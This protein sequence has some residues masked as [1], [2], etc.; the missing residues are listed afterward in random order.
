MRQLEALV[1]EAEAA[2]GE[3]ERI[4]ALRRTCAD[5]HQEAWARPGDADVRRR[6]VL[7]SIDLI[8]QILAKMPR[9]G[10]LMAKVPNVLHWK[11][12]RG[13]TYIRGECSRG[14]YGYYL[15]TDPEALSDTATALFRSLDAEEAA[16]L[17]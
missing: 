3:A 10:P 1:A 11:I 15:V 6:D 5:L 12:P 14:E 17:R 16:R 8:R 4:R 2:R 7:M 9:S 13:E